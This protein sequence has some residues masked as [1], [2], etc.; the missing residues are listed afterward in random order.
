MTLLAQA[1]LSMLFAIV[2]IGLITAILLKRSYG[3]LGRQKRDDSALVTPPKPRPA[4]PT[5]LMD[6]PAELSRWEVEMYEV[7]R[8]LSAELTTR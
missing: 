3:Y 1:D 8:D 6:G 2:A 5:R 7:A 4:P